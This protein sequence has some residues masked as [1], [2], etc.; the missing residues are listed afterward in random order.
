VC[1]RR[2]R[3]LSATGGSV[4]V[5]ARVEGLAAGARRQGCG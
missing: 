3:G 2:G 1:S 4:R 5:A